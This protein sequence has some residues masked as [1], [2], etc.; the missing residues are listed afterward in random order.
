M[1]DPAKKE[2][3]VGPVIT[4]RKAA[5]YGGCESS[6]FFAQLGTEELEARATQ[7][8]HTREQALRRLDQAG[9]H[10]RASRTPIDPIGSDSPISPRPES[11]SPTGFIPERAMNARMTSFAPSK[12]GTIRMSRRIFS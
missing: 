8:E 11:S 5:E 9:A 7:V 6:E 2:V 12:M 10:L 4:D 3:M 1:G